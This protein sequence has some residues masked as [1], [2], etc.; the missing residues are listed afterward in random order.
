MSLLNGSQ[1]TDGKK[2]YEN[3]QY[4]KAYEKF[5][6][7]AQ[8]GM[9]AKYNIGIM[10]E[11]GQGVEKD[12]KKALYFYT[13]S[14]NDGYS[15]AQNA[16]GNAYLKGIGVK[17]N[18]KQAAVYYSLAAKQ[19]NKDAIKTLEI[20]KKHIEK[21]ADLAYLTVRSNVNDDKVYLNGKY[22]GKTKIVIPLSPNT[23]NNIEVKKDG[24]KSYTFNNL[25]L[26]PKEKKTV[27][28]VLTK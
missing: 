10:Y 14:A 15:K 8:E 5:F 20:L 17:K 18:I 23:E 19:N 1:L 27:K 24:Y 11:S 9:I 21:K 25:V 2:L 13:L 6:A 7:S 22:I 16:L 28:A 3:K 4:K 26:K 12:I